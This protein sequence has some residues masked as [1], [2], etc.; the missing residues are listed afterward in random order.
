MPCWKRTCICSLLF[1]VTATGLLLV[2]LPVQGTWHVVMTENFERP[3]T[4]WPWVTAGN[5]WIVY[6]GWA[7][8]GIQATFYH[9]G[10]GTQSAWCFM[11]PNNQN[12][13]EYD[14]YPP[15]F[16]TYMNWGPFDLSQAHAALAAFYIFNRSYAGDSVYWAGATNS[17]AADLK[18]GGSYSGTLSGWE[19]RIMNFANLRNQQGDSVSLLGEPYVYVYFLFR[20]NADANVD[21]G[22]FVDDI[23][24]A[25][26]DGLVDLAAIR[27]SLLKPDSTS[28]MNL[29]AFG[30]TVIAQLRWT[31]SGSGL[32][33]PFRLVGQFNGLTLLDTLI[34]WA[35]GE[36]N[37]LSY[38]P[39][40]IMS[41]GDHTF[42]F[43]LDSENEI[44]ETYE[45]NNS[46]D[47]TFHVDA[48]NLPP[49]F[50]W[51]RPGLL[52]DTA[53]QS[54]LLQWEVDDVDDDA[55]LYIYY[56]TDTL[57][58][59]GYI[60]PGG[61]AI[62]EDTGPDTLRWNVAHFPNG[63]EL[64]PYAR[65]DDPVNSIQLY[66]RAPV[67]IHHGSAA[68]PANAPMDLTFRLFQN[69]PNPFNETTTIRFSVSHPGLT[70]LRVLDLLGRRQDILL[71]EQLSPGNYSV[72][73]NAT[74][75][76]SGLFLC[77]LS[78][79]QGT[80]TRKMVL[81]K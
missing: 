33:A 81:L 62:S 22:G 69:Y 63:Q 72:T 29:P 52:A 20:S 36:R 75:W 76:S 7:R 30:D 14:R 53:N 66:A 1:S 71:Q 2:A 78:S 58:F 68:P 45:E 4:Q 39:S 64:W 24:V 11:D 28:Y 31:T 61:A 19:E 41:S 6:P 37:Y 10:V 77:T 51:I 47:S 42:S 43:E 8:W 79:P 80:L 60:L 25:W 38:L 65:V 57:D 49:T 40:Q 27:L 26:D 12:D 32:L 21:M 16:Y 13:P 18:F 44:V 35:E 55:L 54:Y 59:N 15:N 3:V 46:L 34:D 5:S 17:G 70:T 23:V 73:F 48:P 67:I 50:S 9:V 56:D 74:G